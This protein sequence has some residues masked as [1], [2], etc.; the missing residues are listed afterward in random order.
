MKKNACTTF[1]QLLMKT[2]SVNTKY[3]AM[4]CLNMPV[5]K[6]TYTLIYPKNNHHP[7]STNIVLLFADVAHAQCLA[8]SVHVQTIVKAIIQALPTSNRH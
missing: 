5:L 6:N 8:I 2:K 7:I 3:I 4:H 1:I